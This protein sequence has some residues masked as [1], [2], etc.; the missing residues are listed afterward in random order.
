MPPGRTDRRSTNQLVTTRFYK[1]NAVFLAFLH[2]SLNSNQV[3]GGADICSTNQL[4]AT[5]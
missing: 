4:V 2:F 3:I 1:K 5:L